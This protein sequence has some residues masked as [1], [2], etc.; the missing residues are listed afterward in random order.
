MAVEIISRFQNASARE[1]EKEKFGLLKSISFVRCPESFRFLETQIN[2]S[3]SET[4]RCNA[5]VNLAW[6]LDSDELPVIQQY[7]NKLS[8]SVQEK[9]AVA[10]AL[11]I[12]GVHDSLPR[13]VARSLQMLD[14]ICSDT[15]LY[16]LENCIVSY[17]LEGGNS[18]LKFFTSQLQQEKY[19]LYAALFLARLGEHKQTFPIFAVALNS[20]DDYEVHTAILGLAAMGTEEAVQLIANL[21][22]EKNRYSP[23]K[24]RWSF[25]FTNFN[26]RR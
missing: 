18:A 7:A 1:D 8:L 9:S 6:M 15:S 24:M 4:D 5:L 12:Y 16:V 22:P 11:M 21:P 13:L 23:K 14:E 2:N 25:N 10:A 17:F 19:K 26:E 20:E 3:H